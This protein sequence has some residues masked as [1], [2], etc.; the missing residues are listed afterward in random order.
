MMPKVQGIQKMV[1][2]INFLSDA[3]DL[4][5]KI[6]VKLHLG[7]FFSDHFKSSAH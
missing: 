4:I 6:I 3:L 2:H 1:G 5:N 7:C